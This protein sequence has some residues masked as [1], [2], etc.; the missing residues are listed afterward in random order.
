M[1]PELIYVHVWVLISIVTVRGQ[2]RSKYTIK[3]ITLFPM[4]TQH[5]LHNRV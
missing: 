4:Q 1:H 2:S 5:V 3:D